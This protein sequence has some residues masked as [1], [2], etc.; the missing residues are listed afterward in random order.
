LTGSDG[1]EVEEILRPAIVAYWEGNIE[2]DIRQNGV[3][4]SLVSEDEHADGER[5]V[6]EAVS[7]ILSEYELQFDDS[8]VSTIAEQVDVF[9][10]IAA[11]QD[12]DG[13]DYEYEGRGGGRGGG[14]VD[15]ID[16][17]FEMEGPMRGS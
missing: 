7:E 5:L 8:D 1:D 6:E 16:D 14:D 2:E 3:L 9:S 12:R 11:N 10:I 13:G 4:A 15:V 17:L